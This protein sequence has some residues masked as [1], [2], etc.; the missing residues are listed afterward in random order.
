LAN[1]RTLLS[2]FTAALAV[3]VAGVTLIRFFGGHWAHWAGW[4]LLPMAAALFI[5]GLN[6]YFSHRRVIESTYKDAKKL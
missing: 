3:A 2:F 5:Y 1:Q 4:A 6:N